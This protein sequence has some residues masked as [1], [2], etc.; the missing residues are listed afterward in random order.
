MSDANVTACNN[1]RKPTA[2]ESERDD[3]SRRQAMQVLTVA[4]A[5]GIA[6]WTKSFYSRAGFDE[7]RWLLDPTVRLAEM[8]GSGWFELETHAGWLCRARNFAVVPACAG[9]NFLIA[10]FLSLAVGLAHRCR[11]LRG[12]AGVLLASVLA[13]YATTLLANALR[14][15]L[16]VRL[17]AARVGFGP[18]TTD[19][20]HELLGIC[21]YFGFLIALFA[22]TMRIA[23][24]RH[25]P[26]R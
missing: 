26:A 21:V 16:A 15:A 12:G 6:W 18:F 25:E 3:E 2:R 13:A 1:D 23:E 22:V 20:L 14:I 17:H 5:L 19:R 11:D 7:L 10:A 8:L 9:V 24:P 4:A